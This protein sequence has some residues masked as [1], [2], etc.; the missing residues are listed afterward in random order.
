[1]AAQQSHSDDIVSDINIVPL[2]DIIL[3][4]LIIFMVTSQTSQ[5][6]KKIDITLPESSSGQASQDNLVKVI[7]NKSG[8]I[9]LDGRIV[10]EF[11]LREIIVEKLKVDPRIQGL[12]LAD[13][14][15]DYGRAVK[16][17]DWIKK[18]GLM[19]ISIG[20]GEY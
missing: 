19:N 14:K 7:L 5:Q 11:E 3:V 15:I 1:M 9:Y 20:V 13:H 12:L 16:L 18:A 2:V 4:V 8:D 17:L 6:Q 10:S